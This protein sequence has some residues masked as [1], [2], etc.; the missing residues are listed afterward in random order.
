MWLQGIW[1]SFSSGRTRTPTLN[2][3]FKKKCAWYLPYKLLDGKLKHSDLPGLLN[4]L[5]VVLFV[6]FLVHDISAYSFIVSFLRF[7]IN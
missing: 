3:T 6:W 4:F 7:D 1:V 5:A 2:D